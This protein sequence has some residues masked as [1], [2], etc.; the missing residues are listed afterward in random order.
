MHL[1]WAPV[2]PPPTG[3]ASTPQAQGPEDLVRLHVC[4]RHAQHSDRTVKV[5]VIHT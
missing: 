1:F 2:G 3:F 5:L 4:V